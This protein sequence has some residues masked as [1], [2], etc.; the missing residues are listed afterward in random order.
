M[1][2]VNK[3]SVLSVATGFAVIMSGMTSAMAGAK[4]GTITVGATTAAVCTSPGTY[5]IDLGNYNGTSA[6]TG[7]AT[8]AFKCTKSTPFTIKLKPNGGAASTNGSLRTFPVSNATPIAYTL[9]S[10]TFTGNGNGLT[11]SAANI[12]ATPNVTVAADQNPI[13]GNYSDTITIE[14]TYY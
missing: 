10:D 12:G 9:D 13:P 6:V 8:I 4:T 1:K 3:Y 2:L 11:V 7:N 5:R 14:V